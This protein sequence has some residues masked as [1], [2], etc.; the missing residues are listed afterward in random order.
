MTR[1]RGRQRRPWRVWS[2][3]HDGIAD[4][5]DTGAVSPVAGAG[6]GA[7][8]SLSSDDRGRNALIQTG[9]AGRL[10]ALDAH[11]PWAWRL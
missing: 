4:V 10:L 9:R 1:G 6:A 11:T 2:C 8:R 7:G 5:L 3:T